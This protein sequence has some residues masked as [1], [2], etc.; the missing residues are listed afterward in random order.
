MQV[1]ERYAE[2]SPDPEKIARWNKPFLI[3]HGGAD[4]IVP[5]QQSCALA[6]QIG[7]FEAYRLDA[8]GSVETQ[9]PAGMRR[10]DVERR[11]DAGTDLR[12]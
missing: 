7:G 12:R 11:A 2:R 10:A 4:T 3:M 6:N 9:P 1:P 5:V 8:S